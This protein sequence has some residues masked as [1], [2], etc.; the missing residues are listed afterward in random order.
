MTNVKEAKPVDVGVVAVVVLAPAVE[1]D[2]Q[3][4]ISI[5]TGSGRPL[6]PS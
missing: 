6:R 4:F 5:S 1:I 3:L 2:H